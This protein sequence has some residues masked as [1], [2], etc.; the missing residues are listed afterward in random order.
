MLDLFTR[1]MAIAPRDRFRSMD[2]LLRALD[3]PEP[4][5]LRGWAKTAVGSLL[6]AGAVA[7]LWVVTNGDQTNCARADFSPVVWTDAARVKT[8]QR[9]AEVLSDASTPAVDL[10]IDALDRYAAAVTQGREDVCVADAKEES[11]S[12]QART[13]CLERREIVLGRTVEMFLEDPQLIER[14]GPEMVANLPDPRSCTDAPASD[15]DSDASAQVVAIDALEAE[16]D[17]VRVLLASGKTEPARR[18]LEAALAVRGESD[19]AGAEARVELLSAHLAD[20][21][22]DDDGTR[23]AAERAFSRAL[24]RGQHTIAVEAAL[25]LAHHF[26]FDQNELRQGRFWLDTAQSL[27]EQRGA[28]TSLHLEALVTRGTISYA[29]GRYSEAIEHYRS[30]VRLCDANYPGQGYRCARSRMNLADALRAH[31]DYEAA[32]AVYR[33]AR[34]EYLARHG[35]DDRRTATIANNLGAALLA[36]GQHEAALGELREALRVAEEVMGPGHADTVSFLGNLGDALLRT[37][38]YEDAQAHFDRA[39]TIIQRHHGADHPLMGYLSVSRAEAS[40]GLH[41]YDAAQQYANRALEIRRGLLG[42]DHPLLVRP[43]LLLADASSAL[44]EPTEAYE[45]FRGALQLVE[46]ASEVDARDAASERH[47]CTAGMIS[48]LVAMGRTDDAWKLAQSL[49]QTHEAAPP[50]LKGRILFARAQL[51][52]DSELR[53]GLLRRAHEVLARDTEPRSTVLARRIAQ[54]RQRP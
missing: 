9:A 36:H 22:G 21:D 48:A 8:Q 49:P 44:G 45:A 30:A 7:S 35:T 3:G 39:Q 16:L 20:M 32:V 1:G 5:R 33:E 27:I 10:T 50:Y 41:H 26:S 12:T 42:P 54:R 17:I 24:A 4:R 52:R 6:G 11:S 40:L 37:G 23:D 38:A 18:R 43:L 2:E 29:E 13:R 14:H 25:K 19:L 46:H 28:R 51:A 53:E 15:D 31:G 47:L 34:D